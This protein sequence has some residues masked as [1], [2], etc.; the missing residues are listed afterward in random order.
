MQ[1]RR[2]SEAAYRLLSKGQAAA[3][4]REGTNRK[5]Y[6]LVFQDVI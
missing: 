6:S 5:R 1:E 4:E 2:L 3:P